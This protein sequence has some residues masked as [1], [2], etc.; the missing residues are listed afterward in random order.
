MTKKDYYLQVMV[1]PKDLG[2]FFTTV[3]YCLNGFVEDEFSVRPLT[4][5]DILL[6]TA[7]QTNF[8]GYCIE[9]PE[10]YRVVAFGCRSLDDCFS[11]VSAVCN[12]LGVEDVL[13]CPIFIRVLKLTSDGLLDST[14]TLIRL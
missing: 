9:K 10:R 3:H 1:Q 2:S 11:F 5:N 12:S 6:F 14:V 7:E 8:I 13:K 4:D